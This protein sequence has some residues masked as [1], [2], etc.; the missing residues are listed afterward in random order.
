MLASFRCRRLWAAAMLA[1]VAPPAVAQDDTPDAPSQRLTVE[2]NSRQRYFLVG[3]RPE[4]EAPAAGY[5]LLVVLP[6]GDG[7]AEFH[8]FVRRIFQ[9]VLLDGFLLAQPVAPKWSANQP[10][11]WPTARLK[12]PGMKFTTEE[13]VTAVIADVARRH[14]LDP[15]RVYVLGWSSGGPAA[16]AVTLGDPKVAGAFVAMSVFKPEQL[17]PLAKAKGRAFYVYHSPQDAIPF[18]MAERAAAD[19]QAKA[20]KVKLQTYEGGHGWRGDV[21]GDLRA[22]IDWLEAQRGE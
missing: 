8:P 17:P 10:V 16:Y 3:P 14:K 11:T 18:S 9:K 2:G 1:L 22:G 4:T 7:S 15:K 20:A 13:F 6:G 19:L 5:G 21:F 12:V